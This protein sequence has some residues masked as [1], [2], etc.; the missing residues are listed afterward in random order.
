[1]HFSNILRQPVISA[2]EREVEALFGR[3]REVGLPFDCTGDDEVKSISSCVFRG[4]FSSVNEFKPLWVSL[5]SFLAWLPEVDSSAK[6]PEF[7][8]GLGL[9]VLASYLRQ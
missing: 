7:P 8:S 3:T 1:M 9:D 4:E 2:P 5:G 6:R